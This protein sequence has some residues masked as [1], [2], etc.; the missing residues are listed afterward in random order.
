MKC[1]ENRQWIPELKIAQES[2][3]GLLYKKS[4][5]AQNLGAIKFI[6][7]FDMDFA[8]LCCAILV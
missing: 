1:C 8:K 7:V 4:L 2:K 6:T 5:L 3:A